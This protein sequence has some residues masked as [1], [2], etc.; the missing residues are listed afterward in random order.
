LQFAETVE[1]PRRWGIEFG[2][3]RLVALP[4]L[5][6]LVFAYLSVPLRIQRLV[7]YTTLRKL[8]R[9]EK[10]KEG[11][12]F[13]YVRRKKG[14]DVERREKCPGWGVYGCGAVRVIEFR[15]RNSRFVEKRYLPVR[16]CIL[17]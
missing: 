14:T 5:V 3:S 12:G 13:Q 6:V 4:V 11:T 8:G 10:A 17:S 1:T 2:S 9:E 7:L 15:K 16:R